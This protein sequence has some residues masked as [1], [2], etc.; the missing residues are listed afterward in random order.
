M[1]PG[2]GSSSVYHS[3]NSLTFNISF[4]T[5]VLAFIKM[6]TDTLPLKE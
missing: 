5:R 3:H 1:K 4:R 2:H 6:G